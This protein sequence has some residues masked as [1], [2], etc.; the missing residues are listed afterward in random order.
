MKYISISSALFA[1][2]LLISDGGWATPTH[3]VVLGDSLSDTGNLY[4]LTGGLLPPRPKAD[5]ASES[6]YD[7]GRTPKRFSN[8]DVWT[9]YVANSRGLTVN[10]VWTG[11]PADPIDLRGNGYVDN[12]AVANSFTGSYDWVGSPVYGPI[13]NWT[14]L[15]NVSVLNQPF[16]GF[17]GLRQ[18]ADA[19]IAKG[20]S[21]DAL[22][23][24]WAG[25]NDLFFA[26]ELTPL[27][28]PN[29]VQQAVANIQGVLQDLHAQ[30]VSK[31]VVANLPDLGATPFA[32]GETSL[33]I[34]LLDNS[35]ALS[36]AA[37]AFNQL[38]AQMLNSLSFNVTMVDIGSLS[39]LLFTDPQMFGFT[40]ATDPCLDLTTLASAC[41]DQNKYIFWDEVHPTTT[42]HGII[43]QAFNAAIPEPAT[44]QLLILGMLGM[45][46]IAGKGA[47]RICAG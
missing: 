32:H 22:H 1:L 17:P 24:I 30:G 42:A 26:P 13:S 39:K 18:Q 2:L 38:L 27:T 11:N 36:S 3:I 34:S 8:G 15:V 29:V 10:S 7:S 6:L 12:F 9:D 41:S 40:N 25:A 47:V 45:L 43:A 23:I 33:P 16:F 20:V 14:D 46:L 28:A 44:N 21:T 31:F 19:Y 4:T 37:D 35:A 5:P